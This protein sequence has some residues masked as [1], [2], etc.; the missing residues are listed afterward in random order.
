[1]TRRE[2]VRRERA[3]TAGHDAYLCG[4]PCRTQE[5]GEHAWEEWRK[6]WLQAQQEERQE[7]QGT[8]GLEVEA[9]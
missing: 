3:V 7:G 1:M 2:Q 4:R 5:R 8:L 9:C 6:G